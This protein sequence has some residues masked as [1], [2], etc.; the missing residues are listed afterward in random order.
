MGQDEVRPMNV[1]GGSV[2]PT[3]LP[4]IEQVCLEPDCGDGAERQAF[5]RYHQV[6]YVCGH[7]RLVGEGTDYAEEGKP[8]CVK[9]PEPVVDPAACGD[10]C[11]CDERTYEDGVNERLPSW[12]ALQY[13]D[14]RDQDDDERGA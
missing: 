6:A 13:E 10:P 5:L 2:Q 4:R 11:Q 7:P 12:R 8:P 9:G 3:D 1:G 14:C